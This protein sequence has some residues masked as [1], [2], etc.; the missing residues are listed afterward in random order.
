M[1]PLPATTRPPDRF[2][3]PALHA[4]GRVAIVLAS[5]LLA[6]MALLC[7]LPAMPVPGWVLALRAGVL[8]ALGGVLYALA[9]RLRRQSVAL[10]RTAASATRWTHCSSRS[11]ATPWHTA[12]TRRCANRSMCH[13]PQ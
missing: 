4:H 1:S 6:A 11:S 8:C 5:V 7:F 9:S 10:K 13:A 2:S 12:T 3:I